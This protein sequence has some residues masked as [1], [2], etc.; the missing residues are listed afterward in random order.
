MLAFVLRRVMTLLPLLLIVSLAVFLVLRLG[1]GDPAM[2]YLRLSQI[3]PTDAALAQAR[4]DLG[5]TLPLWEQ[6][7]HWLADLVRLDLGHSWVTGRPV[8][9]ELLHYLPATLQLA[10]TALLLTIVV[11][12]PLGI[13]AALRK[14]RWPDHLTRLISFIGVA[15]PSFWLGFLLILLFSVTLGWL[16]AMGRGG[17]QH[18]IMPAFATA[19]M[20]ICINM[21]LIRSAVLG[22]LG[23]RHVAYARARGVPELAVIGRHVVRNALIPPVTAIGLHVGELIGGAM[24]VEIVFGWPGVGRYALQAISNQDYPV[25]QGFILLMTSVFVLCNLL[26]DILYAWLDP[27]I[28]LAAE[29][30]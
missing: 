27:R 1:R 29:P 17:W 3:P 25:L 21:R 10:G 28:R 6:Y 15:V 18:L 4:L 8:L 9:E 30:A 22:Q 5:L 23:D 16:P 19:L 20:S 14:D 11:S 7:L 13:W 26:V 2:V 24:V 12:A